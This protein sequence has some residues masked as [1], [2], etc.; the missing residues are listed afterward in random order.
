MKYFLIAIFIIYG[1]ANADSSSWLDEFNG[2]NTETLHPSQL[3]KESINYSGERGNLQLQ[4]NT[5]KAFNNAVNGDGN[6]DLLTRQ[7]FLY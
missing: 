7:Y 2:Q 4:F 3:L 5:N 6:F 1:N